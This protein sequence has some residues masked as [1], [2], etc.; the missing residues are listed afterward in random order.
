MPLQRVCHWNTHDC[1]TFNVLAHEGVDEGRYSVTVT[2]K[3][4][5]QQAVHDNIPVEQLLTWMSHCI[6]NA[7]QM[8]K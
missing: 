6:H 3:D 7:E 2:N 5:K 1:Q 8:L 4:G